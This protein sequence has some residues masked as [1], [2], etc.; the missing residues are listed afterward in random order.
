[1]TAGARDWGLADIPRQLA[2]PKPR[3]VEHL[4]A[5]WRLKYVAGASGG[6]D[7]CIF[8]ASADPSRDD[9]VLIRTAACYAILNLYPYNNG[10]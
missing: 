7:S 5:P 8:C 9:L 2:L 1:M 10:H 3:L 4:W 6:P